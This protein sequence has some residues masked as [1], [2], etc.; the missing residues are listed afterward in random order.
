MQGFFELREARRADLGFAGAWYRWSKELDFDI[1]DGGFEVGSDWYEVSTFF[2]V[3]GYAYESFQLTQSRYDANAPY[4]RLP[5]AHLLRVLGPSSLVLYKHPLGCQR[6]LKYTSFALWL[7]TSVSK[8][9]AESLT[10][11]R[12][13]RP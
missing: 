10:Y 2:L 12:A 1:D 8:S 5:D 9:R 13:R 3:V 11:D 7:S 6:I 4:A